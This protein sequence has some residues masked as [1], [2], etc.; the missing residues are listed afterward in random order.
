M[1]SPPFPGPGPAASVAGVGAAK[2][3][4]TGSIA[5]KPAAAAKK[6]G[7]KGVVVKKKKTTSTASSKAPLKITS[8]K[9]EGK[10]ASLKTDEEPAAKR[11]KASSP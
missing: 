9:V 11:R 8:E 1:I 4:L 2:T 3:N 6:N 5:V 7:L 10:D